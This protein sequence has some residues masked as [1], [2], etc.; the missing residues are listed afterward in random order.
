ANNKQKIYAVYDK[1]NDTTFDEKNDIAV[2]INLANV[3]TE[4]E[5]LTS[6]GLDNDTYTLGTNT[7]NNGASKL[8]FYYNNDVEAGD[9][10]AKLVDTVKLYEGV[11]NNAYLAFDFDL[12]VHLDSVQVT[13]DE[14]GNEQDTAIKAA[15]GGG[16]A[17]WSG[18]EGGA[19]GVAAIPD[20]EITS[21]TWNATP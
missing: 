8:K 5:Q 6:I 12:N 2:E 13:F 14:N 19:T 7:I 3:G 18:S 16:G 1:D 17:V 20:K 4:A 21:I 9:S 10:T 15:T 11:T